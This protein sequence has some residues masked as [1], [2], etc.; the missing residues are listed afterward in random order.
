AI[1]LA[2]SA[3][4]AM[5]PMPTGGDTLDLRLTRRTVGQQ[6]DPVLVGL[7]KGLIKGFGFEAPAATVQPIDS[8]RTIDPPEM[9]AEGES[10]WVGF[11]RIGLVDNAVIELALSPWP[12]KT[13]PVLPGAK[14]P[15]ADRIYT[16]IADVR[17]R[18]FELGVLGG[19]AVGNNV[20][21]YDQ[22]LR[23]T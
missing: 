20:P 16:N 14:T 1:A 15:V 7:F 13:M 4:M 19:V 21:S 12:T 3:S 23:R 10:I 18:T 8:V 2:S 22:N 17:E 9:K 11:G 6:T 5:H